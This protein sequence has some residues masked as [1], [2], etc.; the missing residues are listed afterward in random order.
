MQGLSI[1]YNHD[2]LLFGYEYYDPSVKLQP[3]L[4]RREMEKA[5]TRRMSQN[6]SAYE[7]IFVK[8]TAP[9]A[10]EAREEI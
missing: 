3:A 8:N 5:A 4:R 6:V 2:I 7:L 1:Q 10:L 9:I